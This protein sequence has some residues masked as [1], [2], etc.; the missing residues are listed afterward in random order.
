MNRVAI[1][2]YSGHAYVVLDACVKMG[3]AIKYY[4]DKT[5]LGNRDPY[6][7]SYLGDESHADFVWDNVEGFVLGIGDNNIR[8]RIAVSVKAKGKKL[9]SV[10][11]PSS[12]INDFVRL[13][14][15]VFL[16]SNCVL[17]PFAAVGD[18]CIINT[19]AIVEHECFLGSAV[20]IA[21]GAVLA[22]N[23][24]VGDNTFIGANSVIKQGV[25]IGKNVIVGAGSVVLTDIPDGEKWVGNP[26]RK[27]KK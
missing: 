8:A 21:P 13:G 7:L 20:H 16:A 19:G 27:M 11:H 25:K 18:Y 6:G 23:V 26:A 24:Q 2:G 1:I 22:G 14:E 17:N 9:I 4:C 10:V 12:L 3:L 15:G 5:Y